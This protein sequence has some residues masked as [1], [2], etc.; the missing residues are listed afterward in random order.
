[1][2]PD[3]PRDRD[4]IERESLEIVLAYYAGTESLDAAVGALR[5]VSALPP[6]DPDATDDP[7]E[8]EGDPFLGF[9]AESLPPEQRARFDALVRAIQEH[10]PDTA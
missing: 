6:P 1:M 3:V 4:R 8:S 7:L 9:D 2:M 10:L 5:K